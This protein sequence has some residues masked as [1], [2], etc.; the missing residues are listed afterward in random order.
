MLNVKKI[1]T[2]L[3][4]LTMLIACSAK[5]QEYFSLFINGKEVVV[6]YDAVDALAGIEIEN[7]DSYKK[8]EK[9]IITYAEV[10]T[11]NQIITI[12][13]I[14]INQSIKQ[15]CS[16]FNGEFI[17]KNGEACYISKRVNGRENYIILHGDILA[18]DIDVVDRI[19]IA[20]DIE[21]D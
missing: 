1:I 11:N 2:L 17:E 10:Y 14:S 13:G 6:G 16:D 21:K 15:T 20:Y 12:N 19:E 18:D 9:E 8:D 4:V 7:F 3:F 5:K